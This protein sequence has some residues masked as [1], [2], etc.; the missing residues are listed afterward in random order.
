MADIDVVCSGLNELAIQSVTLQRMY[1]VLDEC[2]YVNN[3]KSNKKKDCCSL[4]SLVDIPLSQSDCI[5]IGTGVEKFLSDFII[6]SIPDL[7]DIKIKNTKG[8][9]EKDHLFRDEQKKMI[10]YAEVKGNLK[11]DTEK[12]TATVTKCKALHQELSEAYPG[13][14]V[15]MFLVSARYLYSKDISK[16]IKKKYAKI[17]GNLVGINEYLYALGYK[18]EPITEQEYRTFMTRMATKMFD[19]NK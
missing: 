4:S 12:G 1:R 9:K 14:E 8:E 16:T 10:Y 13:Y 3:C 5:K 7:K 19:V 11:L 6:K 17:D 2:E 15:Q 18:A